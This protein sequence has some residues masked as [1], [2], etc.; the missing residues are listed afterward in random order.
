[1]IY[2]VDQD[3]MF[4]LSWTRSVRPCR[5]YSKVCLAVCLLKDI[6]TYFY[7]CNTYSLLIQ[8]LR[9]CSAFVLSICYSLTS[10]LIVEYKWLC[11][12]V[13][14]SCQCDMSWGGAHFHRM[15]QWGGACLQCQDTQLSHNATSPSSSG[16][17]C[18]SRTS[19]KV[20]QFVSLSTICTAGPV[21]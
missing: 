7:L 14:R 19:V 15:C 18:L 17:W 4:W 20:C 8:V 12:F 1:M 21:W 9:R 13:D 10:D 2:G 3:A 16:R 6:L 5:V 11:G